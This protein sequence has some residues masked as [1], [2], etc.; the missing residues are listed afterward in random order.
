MSQQLS[1]STEERMNTDASGSITDNH[2]NARARTYMSTQEPENSTA[3]VLA[4]TLAP[5]GSAM[6]HKQRPGG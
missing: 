5:P 1:I 4:K 3:E 2:M 6:A